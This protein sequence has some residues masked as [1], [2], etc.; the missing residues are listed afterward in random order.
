MARIYFCTNEK[1]P[2]ELTGE[3]VFSNETLIF[4]T[5]NAAPTYLML[6]PQNIKMGIYLVS[7]TLGLYYSTSTG[8]T[9]DAYSSHY[10]FYQQQS[11]CYLIIVEFMQLQL[12]KFS[13][14]V[15]LNRK[16]ILFRS[17]GKKDLEVHVFNNTPPDENLAYIVWFIPAQHP[18]LQCEWTFN[19]QLFDSTGKNAVKFIPDSVLPF[20]PDQYIGF[21]AKVKCSGNELIFTILK[22]T[23]NVY[24]SK[25]IESRVPCYQKPCSIIEISIHRPGASKQ[26]VY[27]TTQGTK[28]TLVAN[29]QIKCPGPKQTHIIWNIYKVPDLKTTPDWSKP[30]NPPA[31]RER[32]VVILEV[33]S[34]SLDV[35]LYLFNFTME[36]TSL[37]TWNNIKGSESVFVE[38]GLD[39]LVAV[40]AGGSFRVV[41]IFDEWVLNGSAYFNGKVVQ[42]SQGLSFNW[43]CTKRKTD[44]ASMKLSENGKCHPEQV[45]LKWTTSSDP[46]QTVQPETLQGN[47]LYYFRLVVQNGSRTAQAE[48][49][50]HVK[51]HSALVLTIACTE[52]CG[53]SVNPTEIFC[54]SGK[55]LNCRRSSRPVYY[56]SLHSAQ[57]REISFDWSS[58]STTGRYNSFLCIKAFALMPMAEQ[59]Y[60][61]SLKAVTEDGWTATREHSFYVN[62]PPQTGKCVIKPRT[63]LA[64]RTKFFVQCSGFEDRN[65]PLTYKVIAASDQMEVSLTPSM[66]NGILGIIVYVGHEYKTPQFFLPVGIPSQNFALILYVQ[67]CDALGA[68]SQVSLQATVHSQ[69]EG[70]RAEGHHDLHSLI[71]GPSAPLTPLILA[72]DYFNIGYF[73]YMV[74]SV[75]NNIEISPNNQDFKTDFRQTL[76]NMTARIPISETLETNQVILSICQITHEATEISREAQLLAVRKLKEASEALKKH[77]ASGLGSKEAEV[78]SKAILTG[79]SNVLRA[80]LMNHTHTNIDAIKEAISVTEILADLILQGKV[81]GEHKS[82]IKT[83][84]WSI[85]LWKDEK[86]DIARAFSDKRYCRNCFYPRLEEAHHLELPAEAVISTVLYEFDRNPFPWLLHSEDIHTMVTGFRMTG[87]RSNGDVIR[88]VPDVVEM[89]MIR[90]DEAIFD[91]TIGP[92]KKIPKTTGGFSF[93]VERSTNDIFIQIV[94]KINITFHVFIYLGLNTSHPP[95]AA[96]TASPFS[97]PTPTEMASNIADCAVQGPYIFCLPQSLLWS[98]IYSSQTDRLNISVVIQSHQIVRDQ[99][100]KIV[101]VAIFAAVCLNLDGIQSQWK[102]RTC[103]LGPQTNYAKIHCVCKAKER[104]TRTASHESTGSP[105]SGIQFLAGKVLSFPYRSDMKSF[106]ILPTGQ[107]L[108]AALTVFVIF[109][110]YIF[111]ATWAIQK[112]KA[113][114]KD[115][116]IDL[117]DND[118]FDKIPYL[119]TIYTGSRFSAGTQADVFIELL[120]QN[121]ASDVHMLKHPQFPNILQR[122]SIDTFLLTARKDLGDISSL[123]VWHNNYGFSSHWYLSRVQVQNMD[124][125]QT[126]LFVC[127]KWLAIGKDDSQ[128]ERSFVVTDPSQPLGKMDYF[129]IKVS[130]EL[131]NSHLWLS[132]FAQAIDRSFSRFQRLSCCLVVLLSFLM[133]NT[134]FFTSETEEYNSSLKLNY[135]RAIRIGVKSALTSLIVQCTMLT[136]FKKILKGSASFNTPNINKEQSV[137]DVLPSKVMS[138]QSPDTNFNS[139]YGEEKGMFSEK[140]QKTQVFWWVKY[141]FWFFLFCICIG[142]SCYTVLLGLYFA[143][144]TSSE[145]LMASMT[146]FILSVVFLEVLKIVILSA[147]SAASA[148]RCGNIP[149]S[150]NTD[151]KIDSRG[152]P[153]SE[154]KQLHNELVQLRASTLYQPIK[155]EEITILRKRQDVKLRGYI[156]FKNMICH[157]IFL[158]LILTV[159]NPTEVTN[160]FYFNQL[161]YTKFS[162]GL[163]N[164]RTIENIYTWVKNVFLPL[165]HNDRQPSHLSKTWSKI[166]GLSRMR[167]IRSKYSQT[168]CIDQYHQDSFSGTLLGNIRCRKRY[169]IDTEDKADYLGSWTAPLTAP[170]SNP[171]SKQSGFTYEQNTAWWKYDTFGKLNSYPSRGYSIYFFPAESITNSTKM[172]ENMELK[173]WLDLRTWVVILELTTFNPDMD[174]FCSI[175]VL[176]EFSYIGPLNSSVSVHS[177]K[178]PLFI[179]Q[180]STQII[181]FLFTINMLIIYVVDE[182]R[183]LY[184]ERLNYMKKVANLIN[185]GIKTIC[186]YFFVLVLLKFQLALD[187][188]QYYLYNQEEFIPFHTASQVDKGIRIT[189]GLLVFFIVLKTYR[190]FRFMYDVRLAQ[191]SLFAALPTMISMSVAGGIFFMAFMSIGYQVFGQHEWNYST[192]LYSFTTVLSY[193]ALAFRD[194]EFTSNKLLGGLF[195]ASFMFVMVCIFLNLLQA[196]MITAYVEVKK[197]VYEKSSHEAEMMHFVVQKI[198]RTNVSIVRTKK[199]IIFLSLPSSCTELREISKTFHPMAVK[200]VYLTVLE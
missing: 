139:N 194:T 44:Y 149:W 22:A 39:D 67:V 51:T 157:F 50:I 25:V 185:F 146:S 74:A 199:P 140:M 28:F 65:G 196:I 60:I 98:P 70:K 114:M 19:L 69:R 154:M 43:Y 107:N 150:S 21:V 80:C 64:F 195:L 112:D 104:S 170:I 180:S 115:R 142:A 191:Q 81:P 75:L 111:L 4:R 23:V 53:R 15:Y 134:M 40:V 91:L 189:M 110:I 122:G 116:A 187:L 121:G 159:A 125:K 155:E 78:L 172:L 5:S 147:L 133:F 181:M 38:V 163:S 85:H 49:T 165:I 145:W 190:Y 120:G 77:K 58:K 31:I 178:L 92:D 97:P 184:Q 59:S 32:N 54:L 36:L 100:T 119:V 37:D 52:N 113:G 57:S 72:K 1:L 29:T 143:S 144:E 179:N 186:I 10:I 151:I 153:P 168:K 33:P 166:I 88:I 7:R 86:K 123:H 141:I 148:K 42:P 16:E 84:T 89:I 68:C 188:V 171:S 82:N 183:I 169:G 35:G 11:L 174:I 162:H 14:H 62:G 192:V 105:S 109:I 158:I 83:E 41:S 27:Y 30:F 161:M 79:L 193:C 48:Q 8:P 95:V 126:W 108:V 2:G 131:L 6:N 173:G 12:F 128:I 167:Q 160:C 66:E 200:A 46:V 47:S 197:P 156:F 130:S 61:L 76:L 106:L 99:T 102:E 34:S 56:W 117:P 45:D 3:L 152:M 124:T 135:A 26:K 127:R 73:V 138:Q 18:L 164:V 175:S 132:V 93:E 129:S 176:F 96:Y 55:C 24:G 9:T 20:N 13:I 103:S 137:R 94:P 90:K 136:L 63:G 17:L 177:Y 71:H 101:R 118:P 198:Y 182:C 87:V